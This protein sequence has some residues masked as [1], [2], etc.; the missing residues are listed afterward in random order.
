MVR[1]LFSSFLIPPAFSHFSTYLLPFTGRINSSNIDQMNAFAYIFTAW[2]P[3]FTFPT[4]QQPYIVMGNYV[5]AG[6]GFGAV[7]TVLAIRW[8]YLRDLERQ[9]KNGGV[10]GVRESLEGSDSA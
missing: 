7:L 4:Y 9:R 8:F 5:T 10:G 6:F 2:I 1:C 3:I